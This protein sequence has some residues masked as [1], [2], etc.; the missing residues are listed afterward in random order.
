MCI[1]DSKWSDAVEKTKFGQRDS[2][3]KPDKGYIGHKAAKMMKRSKAAER[4]RESKLEEKAGL[5]KDL[6]RPR[7]LRLKPL[8]HHA[9]RLMEAEKLSLYLSLIHI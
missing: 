5:L 3:I 9:R 2:G 7:E 1:R 4:R 8:S 6:E